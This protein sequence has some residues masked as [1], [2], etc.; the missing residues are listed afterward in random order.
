MKH[1]CKY[2]VIDFKKQVFLLIKS[3][4]MQNISY[5]SSHIIL[6]LRT[7]VAF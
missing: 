1:G 4:N 7:Y 6:I 3:K 5:N 2:K